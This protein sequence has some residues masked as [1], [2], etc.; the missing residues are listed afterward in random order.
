MFL[1]ILLYFYLLDMFSYLCIYQL[2]SDKYNSNNW[3]NIYSINSTSTPM[4]EYHKIMCHNDSSYQWNLFKL[5]NF[6][7]YYIFLISYYLLLISLFFT[8]IYIPISRFFII[9]IQFWLHFSFFFPYSRNVFGVVTTC[10]LFYVY[11]IL[12]WFILNQFFNW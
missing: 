1:I 4:Y 5:I 11:S 3:F 6:Y 9:I 10:Y 12:I 2:H 7:I 8:Y